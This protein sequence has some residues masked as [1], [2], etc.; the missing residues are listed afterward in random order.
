MISNGIYMRLLSFFSGMFQTLT[1][2][3]LDFANFGIQWVRSNIMAQGVEYEK[4]KFDEALALQGGGVGMLNLCIL[5]FGDTQNDLDLIT[6]YS[7][8]QTAW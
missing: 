6:H 2:M 8:L 7:H 5:I 1:L 3:R 4:K